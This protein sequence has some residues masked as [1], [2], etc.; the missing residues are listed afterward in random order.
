MRIVR[1]I[2]VIICMICLSDVCIAKTIRINNNKPIQEQFNQTGTTYVIRGR[3]DFKGETITIPNNSK[4][5]F[6]RH[7]VLTNGTLIGNNTSLTGNPK[8]DG[9]RL[10]GTFS[11]QK[12][13]ASWCSFE[14]ISDFIEDVM[15]LSK[16]SAVIVDCDITMNGQK[17]SVDHLY[18][19]GNNKT[20]TNSDRYY[21]NYGGADVTKLCFLWDKPQVIDPA[22]NYSAVI[23]YHN[24][25]EKDT[26]V[27]VRIEDVVADGGRYCSFFIRQYK[28]SVSP[29]LRTVNTVKNCTFSNFTR[30]AIWTCG[31]TGSVTQCKFLDIGYD[32]TD[33][34]R[35]VT[36]LRLGYNAEAEKAKAIGY[37]VEDCTFK[38]IVAAYNSENDGRELHGLLA[39]G[40]SLL[41]KNNVFNTL[42]TSFS[43]VT[44]PGMDSEILYIKGSYNVI[45]SNTFENGAGQSSNGVVTMKIGLSQENV[46][47]NN[48]FSMTSH[49][50]KF[51]YICGS[52]HIIEGNQFEST[53]G[54]SSDQTQYAIYLGHR[55][56]LNVAESVI[57]RD[58]SFAFSNI[59]FSLAIYANQ[60]GDL[61]ITNNQFFN[62][63]KILKSN[64]RKGQLIFEDNM[65]LLDG[66][67]NRNGGYLIELTGKCNYTALIRKNAFRINNSSLT[68]LMTGGNYCFSNNSVS[69]K[70]S[71]LNSL[72]QGADI[73]EIKKNKLEISETSQL[74][75]DFIIGRNNASDIVV[76]DNEIIGRDL[77]KKL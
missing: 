28:S 60:W 10:K 25:V 40:D 39:Y 57:I 3:I 30:G 21:I 18:L 12:Y 70:G 58:N 35:S 43:K 65:V 63:S 8:F 44:D 7:G 53:Y 14:T 55:D 74:G 52:N 2:I 50:G 72:F 73:I 41:V 37:L 77:F 20:I 42:S 64:K 46:I 62:P 51:V 32:K 5:R 59:S 48:K 47:R 6:R 75:K 27:V 68:G 9:I 1:F 16:E 69:V 36:A 61:T 66:L 23:V 38:N 76:E 22:D 11:N 33:A 45:E 4:I 34:L 31:G 49:G 56:L 19:V 26:T 29:G 13:Y 17:R 24:L 67:K 71:S 15:N 54:D